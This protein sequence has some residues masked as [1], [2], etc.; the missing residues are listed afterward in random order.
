MT[1]TRILTGTILIGSILTGAILAH[2]FQPAPTGRILNIRTGHWE[3]PSCTTDSECEWWYG[4][5]DRV[6]REPAHP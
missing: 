2:A 4:P 5:E 3:H 1:R 6:I